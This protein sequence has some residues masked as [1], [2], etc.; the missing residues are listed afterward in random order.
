MSTNAQIFDLAADNTRKGQMLQVLGDAVRGTNDTALLDLS[1]VSVEAETFSLGD[2]NFEMRVVATAETATGS[3]AAATTPNITLNVAPDRDFVVGEVFKIDTEYCQVTSHVAGSLIVGATRGY[4]G[5]TAAI[6]SADTILRSVAGSVPVTGNLIVPVDATDQAEAAAQIILA[7][8]A[9]R[10]KYG[11]MAT[12]TNDV[13]FDVAYSDAHPANA[14]DFTNGTLA[15]FAGGT[16]SGSVVK[17]TVLVQGVNSTAF[18]LVCPNTPI[19]AT[20]LQLDDSA[21]ATLTDNTAVI[22]GNSVLVTEGATVW[23]DG[24]DS[25]LVDIYY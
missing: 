7:V 21:G 10:P 1:G 17:T 2:A 22:T 13:L 19:A 18:T 11:A 20:V 15:N 23:E 25:V 3:A 14:E 5:S 8:P 6:Q 16:D 9:I 4:A 24:V 12:G